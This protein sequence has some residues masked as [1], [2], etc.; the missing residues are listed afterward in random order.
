[1]IQSGKV[2]K[3]LRLSEKFEP[4]NN[5]PQLYGGPMEFFISLS[6]AII[7]FKETEIKDI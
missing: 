5:F 3:C 4:S 7:Q 1:M 6:Y 2:K